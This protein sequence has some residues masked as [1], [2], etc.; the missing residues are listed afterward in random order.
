MVRIDTNQEAIALIRMAVDNDNKSRTLQAQTDIEDY[1]TNLELSLDKQHWTFGSCMSGTR[2]DSRALEKL[3]APGD[4]D[5][6]SFDEHLR[7]FIAHC[8]PEEAPRY[9]D[10]IYVCSTSQKACLPSVVYF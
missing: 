1:E 2:L 10:L 9:E 4:H 7:S 8:L 3:L 5:F 6:I